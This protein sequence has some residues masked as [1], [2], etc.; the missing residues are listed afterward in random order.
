MRRRRALS[1]THFIF[2]GAAAGF[3]DAALRQPDQA[4]H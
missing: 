1:A 2:S 3:R 4:R